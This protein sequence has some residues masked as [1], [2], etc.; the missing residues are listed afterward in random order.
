MTHLFSKWV[1]NNYGQG[2]VRA[3]VYEI[4]WRTKMFLRF[5]GGGS[6]NVLG[7]STCNILINIMA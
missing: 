6:E 3:G 4:F 1:I 2:G 7:Y 5:M